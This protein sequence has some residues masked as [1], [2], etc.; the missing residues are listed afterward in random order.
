MYPKVKQI[1]EMV[2]L[3]AP[4]P[5]RAMRLPLTRPTRAPAQ[6][7]PPPP[8]FLLHSISYRFR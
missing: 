2:S 7:N 5:G 3:W 4:L 1:K 8:P 6:T